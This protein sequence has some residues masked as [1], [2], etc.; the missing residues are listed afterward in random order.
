MREDQF[1]AAELDQ[2]PAFLRLLDF[3]DRLSTE[4]GE[5]SANDYAS[6]DGEPVAKSASEAASGLG[7]LFG[8]APTGMN[9]FADGDEDAN[10]NF[11]PDML[12][13]DALE[14]LPW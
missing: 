8:S 9:P 12:D 3:M 1:N 14:E 4:G 11:T 13:D 10:E 7:G 2:H 6:D 5:V